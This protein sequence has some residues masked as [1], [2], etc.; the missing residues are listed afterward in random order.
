MQPPLHRSPETAPRRQSLREQ[1]GLSECE[2]E[3]E[4]ETRSR[5]CKEAFFVCPG[6]VTS[7]SETLIIRNDRR[8]RRRIDVSDKLTL[9]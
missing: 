4:T 6:P 9:R 2:R 3:T 8:S 5:I 1:T 7:R